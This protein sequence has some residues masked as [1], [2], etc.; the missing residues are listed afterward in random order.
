M[1]TENERIVSRK[2]TLKKYNQSDKRK[3]VN[4]RYRI[5]ND[6]EIKRKWK[7]KY[8]SPNSELKN[9]MKEYSKYWKN[10]PK[11]KILTTATQK[12]YAEKNKIKRLAKDIVNN[13]IKAGKLFKKPC[14]KCGIKKVEGHHPDYTKPLQVIWLCKKHHTET[15]LA[16]QRKAAGV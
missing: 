5:K 13:A 15:H 1:M 11:G 9:K 7:E 4:K 2:K 10:T 14:F 16:V 3:A 8:H 6:K 12:R